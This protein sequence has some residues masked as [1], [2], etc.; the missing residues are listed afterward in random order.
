MD[1]SN[2]TNSNSISSLT[3]GILSILIPLIGF[4]LGVIGIAISRKAKKEIVITN[5]RGIGIATSGLICSVVGIIIQISI[6]LS[7]ILFAKYTR[8]G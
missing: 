6:I 5:E 7:F 3:L 8:L 4:I 1:F 2:R